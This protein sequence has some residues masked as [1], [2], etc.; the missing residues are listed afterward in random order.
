M[1]LKLGFLL[2][3]SVVSFPWASS[4]VDRQIGIDPMLSVHWSTLTGGSTPPAATMGNHMMVGFW[5][6]S[7]GAKA[8]VGSINTGVVEFQLPENPPQRIRAA[9]LQ[10][11]ARASQ[12]AGGEPVVFEVFGFAGNGQPDPADAILG[13]RLA[14]LTA[15]CTDNPAFTQVIDVSNLVR[16]LSVPSGLR[17]AGFNV[18]K[19]NHRAG[20]SFFGFS[21]AKLTIVVADQDV[22]AVPASIGTTA[23][24][25]TAA[26]GAPGAGSQVD[27][28]R[29]I[30]GLL[31]A[32]GTLMRGGGEKPARDQAGNEAAAVLSNPP[33]NSPDAGAASSPTISGTSPAGGEV[34]VATATPAA[35]AV[36][37]ASR[38][39]AAVNVDIV[40]I[41]LGMSFDEVKRALQAHSPAM[42]VDEA[43]GI[44]NNV[45]ATDY[46]SWV[47]ARGNQRG[48]DG[49]GDAIGVQFPPPPNA[50]RAIFVERFTGFQANQYP[51]FE[52]LRQ[53]LVQKY[54]APSFASEGVMLWTF[55]AAGV[56]IVDNNVNARCAKFPPTDPPAR[57]QNVLF[58][59]Y[60]TAGCGPTVFVRYE[61]NR[62]PSDRDLVRWMSVSLVDDSQ[63]ENMRQAAAR[64]ATQ[65]TH[66]AGSRVAAP[67]L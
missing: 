58:N 43:R 23:G 47:V 25:P 36:P 59:G 66:D 35:G 3:F 45:A 37:T 8:G 12:C 11:R 44:V 21:A 1:K 31:G 48:T 15:N 41:K 13:Q 33:M 55:N 7:S 5:Q 40:G 2:A 39:I 18:R 52:T 42:R 49:S 17:F 32:A 19:T 57:G 34:A 16:Q 30:G 56:Q 10:F 63:F 22:A 50:H 9:T 28:N 61:R 64:F 27:V 14:Q 4:A 29:V 54:G 60:K 6:R 46:L 65:A 26:G 51:L 62:G 53:A 24:A 20:P 38:A 67:K